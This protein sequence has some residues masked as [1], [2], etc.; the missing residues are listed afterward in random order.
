LAIAD[1]FGEALSYRIGGFAVVEKLGLVLQ[2]LMAI[3]GIAG[4]T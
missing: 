1:G 4:M 3:G 2:G